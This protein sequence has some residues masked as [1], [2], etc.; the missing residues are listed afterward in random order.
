ME[1]K[2]KKKMYK[3]RWLLAVNT[4]FI[5]KHNALETFGCLT[6]SSKVLEMDQSS[7]P[8]PVPATAQGRTELFKDECDK[9]ARE[10]QP[11]WRQDV[12][13]TPGDGAGD[14]SLLLS[15]VLK[16]QILH[17]GLGLAR[18]SSRGWKSSCKTKLLLHG[19]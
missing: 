8:L 9:S 3:A 18:R 10:L 19:V 12:A 13:L 11:L 5:N 16:A 17:H 4:L 14:T 1:L 15:E 2:G 6:G 7:A